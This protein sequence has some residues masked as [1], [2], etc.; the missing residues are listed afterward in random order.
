MW[1][2]IEPTREGLYAFLK[3]KLK[4]DQDFV[5]NDMGQVTIKK[6]IERKPKNKFEVCVTFESK[7]IRDVVK[8]QGHNLAGF[9]DEAGMRLQIPDY[10][11]KDFHALMSVAYNL[12][13]SNKDLRRN[14]DDIQTVTD[15]DWRRI[16]P[17]QA[18][19]ALGT[20][21]RKRSGAPTEIDDE[22]ILSL[23]G[24]QSE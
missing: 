1:P 2:V 4:L 19:K 23:L 11:Q 17:Q 6:N 16:R 9:R 12:K 22:E 15:G 24:D 5:D 10:L 3:D 20:R 21:T 13:K 8:A 14:M 7:Q 18:Y